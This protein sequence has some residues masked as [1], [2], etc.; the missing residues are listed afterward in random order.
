MPFQFAFVLL[1]LIFYFTGGVT[2]LNC[3]YCHGEA[4]AEDSW[5]MPASSCCK[6]DIIACN[7]SYCYIAKVEGTTT[8]WISGC[9]DDDFNGCDHHHI[10]YN[11]TL[12]RCQC[13][14]DLC[15]P[16]ER[17]PHCAKELVHNKSKIILAKNAGQRP[18]NTPAN[19]STRCNTSLYSAWLLITASGEL[20]SFF[21]FFF[22]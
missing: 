21:F 14:S 3:W 15:S 19:L 11:S 1:I 12:T 20:P 6:P 18:N 7:R 10:P 5:M 9:T 22:L 4:V 16:I 17:I 2:S 8:F 13:D